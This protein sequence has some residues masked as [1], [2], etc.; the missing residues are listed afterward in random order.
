[1]ADILLAT[2]NA[3]YIHAAVGLRY[4]LANMG[5]LQDRTRILEFETKQRALEIAS[6][7]LGHTPKIVGLGATS[8]TW[9]S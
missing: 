7:I 5:E 6:E 2:I 1:M 8:G 3:R 9:R 4:L